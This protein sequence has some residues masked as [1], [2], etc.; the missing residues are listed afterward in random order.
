MASAH[1]GLLEG[2]GRNLAPGSALWPR[3]GPASGGCSRPG[4][5][6]YRGQDHSSVG[7]FKIRRG[8][9]RGRHFSSAQ[10]AG[11]KDQEPGLGTVTSPC[12]L[13]MEDLRA[14]LGRVSGGVPAVKPPRQKGRELTKMRGV[15]LKDLGGEM[16][17]LGRAWKEGEELTSQAGVGGQHRWAGRNGSLGATWILLPGPPSH[18][19][20]CH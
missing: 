13:C 15:A 12:A 7:H 9:G 10:W 17:P 4:R 6:V 20:C 16:L 19:L 5:A 14:V 18:D 2:H 3:V 1:T 8:P 11:Q